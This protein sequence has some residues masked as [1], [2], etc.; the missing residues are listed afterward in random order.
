MVPGSLWLLAFVCLG[1]A[2]GGSLAHLYELPHK[3][4]LPADEYLVVQ[5]IY[6]GWNL[7][8]GPVIGVIL[9]TLLITLH[10]RRNP[11]VFGWALA[12]FLLVTGTQIVFW[13]WTYPANVETRNWT[14]LPERWVSLRTQWEYSHAAGAVLNLTALVT[15]VLA[16]RATLTPRIGSYPRA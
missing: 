2:L 1:L 10:V 14:T 7:L 13:T 3:L 11:R 15:L 8:A 9:A 4:T 16:T 6:R 12:T 5:Q